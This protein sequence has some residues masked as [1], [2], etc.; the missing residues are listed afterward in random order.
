MLDVHPVHTSLLRPPLFLGVERELFFTAAAIGVP[1][2]GYGDVSLRS[3][4][5]LV[6][7]LAVS[8]FVCHRLT[9]KDHS[10]AS[11]FLAN[12][13]YRDHYDPLPPPGLAGRRP[14]HPRG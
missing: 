4:L 5:V 12:L 1:I 14:P 10:L 2:L 6:P 11:L 8:Y 13:R 3:A 9:A 7:Y